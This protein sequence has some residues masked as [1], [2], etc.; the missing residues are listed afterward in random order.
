MSNVVINNKTILKI[1]C[2]GILTIYRKTEYF[3]GVNT[4]ILRK[5]EKYKNIVLGNILIM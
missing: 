5:F 2:F 3:V 4:Q 1:I